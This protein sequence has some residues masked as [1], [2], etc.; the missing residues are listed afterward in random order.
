[1]SNL[2]KNFLLLLF[3]VLL[4]LVV[5]EIALRLF[6]PFEMRFKPDRIVLPVNKRYIFDNTAKF[7]TKLPK[8]TVHTKNLLGF[9]G[10]PP[11]KDFADYLTIV[12]IGGS[13]TECFYLSDGR[14]WPD[15][16]GARLSRDFPKLWINN[17]GM[18]GATTYRHL[19]LLE[20]YVVKLKPKLVLFLVG[21][22]DVGVGEIHDKPKGGFGGWLKA[23]TN[24]S[25]VYS[26]GLNIYRY[27]IARGRGLHHEEVNLKTQG[28]LDVPAEARQKALRKYR[29][30]YLKYYRARLEKLVQVSRSHNIEPVLITQPTLYGPG[31][32]P[33]TGVDLEKVGMGDHRNGALAYAEIEMYNHTLRQVGAEN[34]VQVIDLAREMP[35]NSAYYYDYLHYTEAG[36]AQVAGII[37]RDLKP[38]LA[39]RFNRR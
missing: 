28:S 11:P 37:Y 10:A 17:A 8:T 31:I 18:D 36:A 4:S 3:G 22:N 21:I 38:F 9:R 35:R 39:K 1:M 26:L 15:L 14:T 6:P 24:K 25:E 5:L 7:P 2:S 30:H 34:R 23:A 27:F 29:D 13:T 33:V 16:L 20:D 19:I 12:T 32:D